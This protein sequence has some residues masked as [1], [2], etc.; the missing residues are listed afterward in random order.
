MAEESFTA[1]LP[2]DPSKSDVRDKITGNSKQYLGNV[3]TEE[4]INEHS[5]EEVDKPFSSYK[6]KLLGQMVKSLGK[7]IIKIYSMEA[8]A[9]LGMTNLDGPKQRPGI[10]PFPKLCTPEVHVR[11]L[12]QIRFI[13]CTSKCRNNYEQTLFVR[14]EF[15]R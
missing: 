9:I 1:L 3:H 15:Y 11:N 10:W 4:Q 7:S 14:T 13:P 12:L 5:E 2:E 6:M 8:C